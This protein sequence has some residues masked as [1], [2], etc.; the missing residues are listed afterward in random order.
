VLDDGK[1]NDSELAYVRADVALELDGPY[2][3]HE[4]LMP[5]LQKSGTSLVGLLKTRQELHEVYGASL[6]YIRGR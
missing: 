5:R 4:K 1:V 6:A 2:T 3:L